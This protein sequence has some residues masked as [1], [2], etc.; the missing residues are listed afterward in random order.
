MVMQDPHSK[1]EID[2]DFVVNNYISCYQLMKVR[3][4]LEWNYLTRKIA[5][6]SKSAILQ[7]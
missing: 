7:Y 5:L 1:I 6:L 2:S 3:N 4:L